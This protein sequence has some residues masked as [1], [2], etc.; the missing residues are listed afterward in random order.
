MTEREEDLPSQTL[1]FLVH[2]VLV[3]GAVARLLSLELEIVLNFAPDVVLV[4]HGAVN[5]LDE[6]AFFL[7]LSIPEYLFLELNAL[8]AELT[9][10]FEFKA[11][12]EVFDDIKRCDEVFLDSY[13]VGCALTL[14]HK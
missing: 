6:A 8:L 12:A 3:T 5:L 4:E 13:S 11:F 2:E 1:D 7:S 10:F 9:L 14:P